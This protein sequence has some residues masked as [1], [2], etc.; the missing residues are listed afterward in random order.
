MGIA[1]LKS[2]AIYSDIRF[3]RCYFQNWTRKLLAYSPCGRHCGLDY[4]MPI[5][6]HS[7]GTTYPSY[8]SAYRWTFNF[9]LKL[10]LEEKA[11]EHI[12]KAVYSPAI[13]SYSGK[14]KP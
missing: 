10:P 8:I 2:C 6:R 13:Q 12:W 4:I 9:D 11:Y 3:V 7:T 5:T 14:Q 1:R